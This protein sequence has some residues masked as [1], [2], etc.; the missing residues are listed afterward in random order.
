MTARFEDSPH[1]DSDYIGSAT[2]IIRGTEIPVDVEIRGYRE[3]IDGV[4]RW[5][6]RIRPN[7]ELTE[8]VGDLQRMPAVIR[9]RHSTRDAFV[10]DPDLWGRYR[11]VGKS[12]PPFHVPTDLAEIEGAHDGRR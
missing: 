4:Y 9:T 11:I 6:G 2:V 1:D 8:I 7:D 10:G 12:T 5:I 3:P